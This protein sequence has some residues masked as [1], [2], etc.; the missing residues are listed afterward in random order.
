MKVEATVKA[1]I[2]SDALAVLK[3]TNGVS[4]S[5]H[6]E[7]KLCWLEVYRD[8]G[9]HELLCRLSVRIYDLE[10]AIKAVKEGR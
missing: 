7:P 4:L 6:S 10:Q 1:E 8:G 5:A 2:A 9:D 3:L